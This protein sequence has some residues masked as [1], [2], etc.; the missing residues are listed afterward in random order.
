M[1]VLRFIFMYYKNSNKYLIL[2]FD[3]SFKLATPC[4]WHVRSPYAI[5]KKLNH[6]SRGIRHKH[7]GKG[8]L[9][10]VHIVRQLRG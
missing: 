6:V 8:G 1:S 4:M 2:H 7:V 9:V 3:V 5:R 10:N